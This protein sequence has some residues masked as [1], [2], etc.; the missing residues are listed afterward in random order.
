MQAKLNSKNPLRN[1]A[2]NLGYDLKRRKPIDM[3]ILYS[4]YSS[5]ELKDKCFLNIG[6]GNFYHPYWI[7][8]EYISEYYDYDE[9]TFVHYDITEMK[10]LPYADNSICLIYSSHTIEH[11]TDKHISYLFDEIYRVLKPGGAVRIT[12][13]N[14]KL[15][16]QTLIDNDVSYWHWRKNWFS[17]PHAIDNTPKKLSVFDYF[18]REVATR[19]SPYYKHSSD[20]IESNEIELLFKNLSYE[21]F[22]NHLTGNLLFNPSVPG[23]HINWWDEQKL[24]KFLNMAN[25]NNTY[26][27]RRNQS[28]KMPF[29]DYIDFDTTEPQMSL[30][31]E[32]IKEE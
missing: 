28:R 24:K 9:N 1:L 25:F 11:M 5:E 8:L 3:N 17:G 13:P 19:K 16:Y 14:L 31:Y 27:A 26:S 7:N 18:I 2:Y 12:C 21:D 22:L 6:A 29:R 4:N 20:P 15:L 10:P 32:A 30:Y 23:E